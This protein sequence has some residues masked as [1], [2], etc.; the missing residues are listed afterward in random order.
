MDARLT[1]RQGAQTMVDAGGDSV[2]IVKE[3]Q[4]QLKA[5]IA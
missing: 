4:P 2:M 1:Q 3:H 5:A